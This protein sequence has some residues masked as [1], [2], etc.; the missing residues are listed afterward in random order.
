MNPVSKPNSHRIYRIIHVGGNYASDIVPTCFGI[1]RVPQDLPID[2]Y[3]ENIDVVIY[4]DHGYFSTIVGNLVRGGL[5]DPIVVRRGIV[6]IE[7]FV[8]SYVD[9]YDVIVTISCD[10]GTAHQYNNSC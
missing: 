4:P 2:S 8:S 3:H 5:K 7:A 6:M 9:V 1:G 10:A